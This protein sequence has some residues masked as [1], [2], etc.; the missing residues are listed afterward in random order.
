MIVTDIISSVLGIIDKIIPD[1]KQ[2][3][4]AK[5]KLLELQQSGDLALVQASSQIVTA[6][7]QSSSWLAANW[8]PLTA[9]SFVTIIVNNYIIYPYLKLFGLPGAMMEIPPDMWRLLDVMLGGYVVSRGFEK[10]APYL[11]GMKNAPQ[12]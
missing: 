10:I 3:A 8:R 4:E 5:L 7:A 1:P 12:I 11:K 6:E 2:A 9:L